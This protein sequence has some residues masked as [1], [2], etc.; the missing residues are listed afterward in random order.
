MSRN[1]HSRKYHASMSVNQAAEFIEKKP[2]YVAY[3]LRMDKGSKIRIVFSYGHATNGIALGRD[4]T[5]WNHAGQ[6]ASIGNGWVVG[7]IECDTTAS[8]PAS[9]VNYSEDFSG[10]VAADTSRDT[11]FVC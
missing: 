1:L 10:E 8:V 9:I 6:R 2:G 5:H 3:I 7:T 4:V 11:Y